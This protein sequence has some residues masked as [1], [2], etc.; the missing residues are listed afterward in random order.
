M[1]CGAA[2]AILQNMILKSLDQKNELV[3]AIKKQTSKVIF[4]QLADLAAIF[5]AFSYPVI[6]GILLVLQ[7]AIWLVPDKNIE[8]AFKN[9]SDET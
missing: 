6:S 9:L 7:S 1:I 4:S 5:F 3:I 8:R 2:Y